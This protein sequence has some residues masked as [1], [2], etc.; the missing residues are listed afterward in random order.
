MRYGDVRR[1]DYGADPVVGAYARIAEI[2]D[3]LPNN[4][5]ETFIRARA[6]RN[7][8]DRIPL[9]Q[10]NLSCTLYAMQLARTVRRHSL[11][12]QC[13]DPLVEASRT[14]SISSATSTTRNGSR[15]IGSI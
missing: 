6:P 12:V 13:R 11:L 3:L 7:P 9:E 15:R 4:V 8:N 1:F 2:I 5:I 10:V 14:N